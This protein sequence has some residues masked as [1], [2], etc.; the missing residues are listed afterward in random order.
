LS[1][2]IHISP[3]DLGIPAKFPSFRP[4]QA[5]ALEFI[6]SAI[7]VWI[8]ANA[9]TGTGKSLLGISA[10]RLLDSKA[11]YLT[12]TKALQD[13]IQSDFSSM[14]MKDMRGAANYPC[15]VY[16]TK[17]KRNVSCD[18]GA[19]EGCANA[20]NTSCPRFAAYE[21]A[22]SSNLVNTN[23][24]YWL[25]ARRSFPNALEIP[26]GRPVELLICDEAHDAFDQLSN[27]LDISISSDEY[28][29]APPHSLDIDG[30]MSEPSGAT[31][32]AW[33]ANRASEVTREMKA[34][35][36]GHGSITEARRADPRYN[37]LEKLRDKLLPL[38]L[39]SANWVWEKTLDRTTF[40]CIWPGQYSYLL[41]SKVPQILL[42]SATLFPYTLK[43]LG[44][45]KDSYSFK[46]FHNDWPPQNAPTYYLPTVKMGYRSTD[47]DYATM[48]ARIDDIIDARLDRKGVIHTVSYDRMRKFLS[49]SK[50]RG[51]MHFNES[52]AASTATA[53]KF[54]N[55][56]PPAILISPSFGTGWDFAYSDC[57][58]QII[59]KI[60][61]P[62]SESRVMRERLKDKDYRMYLT[63]LE[64]LQMIGRGRRHPDDRCETFILDNF[65]P[66]VMSQ[67]GKFA[68][69]S[70][71]YHRIA[72]IPKLPAK[73]LPKIVPFRACF[74]TRSR[75]TLQ[76]LASTSGA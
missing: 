28:S 59:P 2:F 63:L 50:H 10:A 40:S 16:T 41:W 27:F 18:K 22:K 65:F 13:Q 48:A 51:I 15:R 24:S 21:I 25:H 74:S 66:L 67:A 64:I 30:L 11:V 33:A 8:A 6:V 23:Y 1:D 4:V 39:F 60:P 19:E 7:T 44:L 72:S 36:I 55:A 9:Q 14:G 17:Y 69:K 46:R 71:S 29:G 42:L 34:L 5:E 58:Y 49:L 35:V 56:S 62:Y 32:R 75:G 61:F 70:L 68:G 54:R 47:A 57:E 12:S 20:N 26:D 31:W 73:L 45:P 38:S 43:L 37:E 76:K 3:A 53:A 52:S